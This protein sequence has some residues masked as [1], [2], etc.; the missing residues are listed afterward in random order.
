MRLC[1]VKWKLTILIQVVDA[2]VVSLM[3]PKNC[4]HLI[5][6]E[7]R[8]SQLFLLPVPHLHLLSTQGCSGEVPLLGNAFRTPLAWLVWSDRRHIYKRV[9]PLFVLLLFHTVH[10]PWGGLS[11]IP[12]NGTDVWAGSPVME[13]CPESTTPLQWVLPRLAERGILEI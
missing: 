13:P 11:P 12:G 1:A 2:T 7:F 5:L 4:S 10:S 8:I 6:E 9:R 3:Q